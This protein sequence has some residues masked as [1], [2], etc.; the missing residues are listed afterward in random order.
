MASDPDELDAVGALSR[1]PELVLERDTS[2]LVSLSRK[3]ESLE[4]GMVPVCID[5][6]PPAAALAE[7]A[8]YS[9]AGLNSEDAGV[10]KA[11]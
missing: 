4:G 10:G 3:D 7:L 5:E 9:E 6:L 8:M 1:S 2:V 11:S